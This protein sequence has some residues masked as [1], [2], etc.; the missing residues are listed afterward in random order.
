MFVIE[1]VLSPEVPATRSRSK[2]LKT[3][4]K[5]VLSP[6]VIESAAIVNVQKKSKKSSLE[7]SPTEI[8]NLVG[9]TK[10]K[11]L[12]S[13]IKK[14]KRRLHS[15]EQD[16]GLHT[17]DEDDMLSIPP[18]IVSNVVDDVRL[19]SDERDKVRRVIVSL[20]SIRMYVYVN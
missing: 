18:L 20:L 19:S 4:V 3:N 5:P 7:T 1:L 2:P 17:A 8:V 11:H 10:R 16:E 6:D 12:P 9:N 13:V 14:G 15:V